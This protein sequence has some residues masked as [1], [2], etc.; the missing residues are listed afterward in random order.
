MSIIF[1]L[2]IFLLSLKMHPYTLGKKGEKS[3]FEAI[4]YGILFWAVLAFAITEILSILNLLLAKTIIVFWF[5]IAILVLVMLLMKLKQTKASLQSVRNTIIKYLHIW[6]TNRLAFSILLIVLLMIIGSLGWLAYVTVPYNWDCLAYHLPRIMFW[7]QNHSVSHY[8]SN[9]V[10]QLASPVFAEFVDLHIYLMSGQNDKIINLFQ[11]TS[12]VTGGVVVLHMAQKLNIRIVWRI[13]ALMLY[14][15]TPILYAEAITPQVELVATLWLLIFVDLWIPFIDESQKLDINT[16]CIIRLLGMGICV[17]LGYETK[18]SVCVGQFVFI[19]ILFVILIKKN[20]TLKRIASAIL[21]GV[22]PIVFIIAPEICRN[23]MTFG[24]ISSSEVGARQ[25]VGRI[26]PLYLFVN[27][28]KNLC[29]NLPNTLIPNSSKTIHDMVVY[30]AN[31]LHVDLNDLTIS[32]SGMEYVMSDPTNY[33]ND[34]AINPLQVWSFLVAIIAGV[35]FLIRHRSKMFDFTSKLFLYG[36]TISFLIMLTIIR[37][38][39]YEVRY[40]TSYLALICITTALIG[41]TI[42]KKSPTMEGMIIGIL[43][44]LSVISLWNMFSYH[45]NFY[46]ENAKIKPD[47]YFVYTPGCQEQLE[48]IAAEIHNRRWSTIGLYPMNSYP[49]YPIWQMVGTQYTYGYVIYEP[50]NYANV[51]MY[52]YDD[53]NFHP[54]CIIWLRELPVQKT[55]AVSFTFHGMNYNHY[56]GANG[57]YILYAE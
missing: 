14:L 9:D 42:A 17:G 51:S 2:V 23:L 30:V 7:I 55:D 39:P 4:E 21:I 18:P 52:K 40:E 1:F 35:F 11:Y 20:Y 15:S 6:H 57:Y 19:L 44:F 32:E 47:G 41:N 45:K 5:L 10:R 48:W 28:L 29:F 24:S 3:V 12:Y 53:P 25:L 22:F 31:R 46:E 34:R 50:D 13:T 37:W 49:E 27:F 56:I 8:A 36:S 38:E 43:L 26:N 54:D 16:S 33:G